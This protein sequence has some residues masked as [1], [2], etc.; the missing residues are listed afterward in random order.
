LD[1]EPPF[2]NGLSFGAEYRFGDVVGDFRSLLEMLD[3]NLSRPEE[4]AVRNKEKIQKTKL[5]AYGQTL[6]GK[7][8]ERY[9][10]ELDEAL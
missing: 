4:Y 6:D 7:S 9:L 5:A 1:I 10:K 2:K 3:L 8:C